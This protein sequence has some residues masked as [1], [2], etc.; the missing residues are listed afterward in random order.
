MAK[1]ITDNV[2][3]L[4]MGEKVWKSRGSL[5]TLWNRD[6]ENKENG[7]LES[8]QQK[9]NILASFPLVTL[10]TLLLYHEVPLGVGM[11]LALQSPLFTDRTSWYL[12]AALCTILQISTQLWK[13]DR[14][15]YFLVSEESPGFLYY[16]SLSELPNSA[17]DGIPLKIINWYY[18]GHLIQKR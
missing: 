5:L 12:R 2:Y 13:L 9:G 7:V 16:K 17:Q 4:P 6:I 15:S 3:C 18:R 14:K 10:A 11:N 1:I 8:S